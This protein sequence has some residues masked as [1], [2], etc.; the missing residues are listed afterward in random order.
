MQAHLFSTI[1][2]NYYNGLNL[3]TTK[4]LVFRDQSLSTVPSITHY[5]AWNQQQSTVKNTFNFAGTIFRDLRM[6]DIFA[7][8]KFREFEIL[9]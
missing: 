7:R 5:S 1:G 6:T 8:I 2:R 3:A 4:A 9:S